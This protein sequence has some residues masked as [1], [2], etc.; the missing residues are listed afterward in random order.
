M[1]KN[2]LLAAIRNRS[3]SRRDMGRLL[4][5][6]GVALT[7]VPMIGGRALA[8]DQA[9]YFTWSGYD[10]PEFFPGYIEEHGESPNLPVF[11]DEEEGFQKLR[12]GFV[13]DVAHPCSGRIVRWRD[14]GVIQPID[15]SKLSNWGDVFPDLKTING[16]GDGGQQ[17]FIPIDWGNTSIIYRADLVDIQEESWELLWDPRYEGKLSI[18]TD[19]TDTAVITGL[20][21]G[22]ENPYNMTDEEIARVKAKLEEQ[23]PLLRFYWSDPTQLEQGLATGEIVASTAWNSA[24][25]TLREQGIDV[26]FMN[27]KEG[28]LTWCCGAVLCTGAPQP[29]LAHDLMDALISPD[30]GE[31]LINYGYG[32]SNKLSFERVTPELLADRGFPADPTAYLKQGIFSRDNKRLDDLQQMFEAVMA[33]T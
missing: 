18:G 14:G 33:G 17:W 22:V 8:A 29:E 21:V 13:A 16:A 26:K 2:D 15:T 5:T 19:V 30:A 20:L 6:A 10:V 28:I 1:S 24:L 4:A 7:A 23:K 9:T 32:H 12:S 25:P 27:P 31:W 11:A 3:L